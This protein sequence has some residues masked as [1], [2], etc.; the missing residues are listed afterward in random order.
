MVGDFVLIEMMMYDILKGVVV[1][2]SVLCV[3][4]YFD[5]VCVE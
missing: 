5:V 4:Y 3:D 1:F 2:W